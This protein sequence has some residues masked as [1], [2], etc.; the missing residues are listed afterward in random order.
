MKHIAIV[1]HGLSNGGAERVATNLANY[2]A[3][4]YKVLYIAAFNDSP[5]YYV[6]NRV[7]IRSVHTNKRTNVQR[8]IDRN[9]Q[10]FKYIKDFEADTVISFVTNELLL[11]Q[12]RGYTMIYSLR[13][14]PSKVDRSFIEKWIRRYEYAHAKKVIFQ[15]KGAKEYYSQRIQKNGIVI[16]NP[17]HCEKFPYWIEQEHDKRF[18]TACRLT[19]Q[20]NIPMLINAFVKFHSSYPEYNL[21]IYG[22]GEDK[23]KIAQLILQKNCGHYIFLRG[24]SENIHEIMSKSSAFVIS[25]DYEGLSNS[26]LEALAIGIPCICTDCPPGGAREYIED[27]VNGILTPISDSD[28]MA[29]SMI[30]FA[31]GSIDLKNISK[32]AIKIRSK[33]EFKEV[34]KQWEQVLCQ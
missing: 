1:A 11:T 20:K 3:D 33:M 6:D 21:D 26:M 7:L 30:K 25:S 18:I 34:C 27:G 14:D 13:T 32:N 15:T 10:I 23:D 29:S 16:S 22:E 19:Q 31:D 4:Q 8:L 28:Q 17:M 5:G 24:Y 9:Q 12:L 2:F